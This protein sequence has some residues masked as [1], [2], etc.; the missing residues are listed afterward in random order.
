M[1]IVNCQKCGGQVRVL[2]LRV[3]ESCIRCQTPRIK[4]AKD[5]VKHLGLGDVIAL[6][7]HY[8]GIA[9]LTKR[10]TRGSCG[11][12]AR[13]EKLNGIGA[14]LWAWFVRLIRRAR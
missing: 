4:Q 2:S 14:M 11:C 5:V 13:Q 12:D 3:V 10:L 1:V 9:W 7:T 6:L 8:T